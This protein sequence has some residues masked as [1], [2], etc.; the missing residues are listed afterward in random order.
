MDTNL[1]NELYIAIKNLINEGR[2]SVVKNVNTVMV[3]TYWKIGK[4]ISNALDGDNRAEYGEGFIDTLAEKLTH[5]FGKGFVARNLR[6]FRQFYR[7]FPIWNS[8]SSKLSWTHYRMLLRVENAAERQYFYEET[9]NSDLSTREL[10]KKILNSKPA[11]YKIKKKKKIWKSIVP[12][13]GFDKPQTA[14]VVNNPYMMDFLG[15][16][17][18]A[19]FKENRL[20]E[21]LILRLSR[22]LLE[23]NKGFCFLARHKQIM[24]KNVVRYIDLVFYNAFLKCYVVILVEATSANHKS[25]TKIEDYKLHFDNQFRRNDDN[26]TI[27]LFFVVENNRL[28]ARYSKATKEE[29]LFKSKYMAELPTEETLSEDINKEK[30]ILEIYNF[31][32]EGAKDKNIEVLQS[33]RA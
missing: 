6:Y 13:K 25:A 24:F 28:I 22:Y 5:E 10:S 21:S 3:A 33:F 15:L 19:T 18:N 27:G 20:E 8:V 11:S 31:D 16:Q 4:E 26:P 32:K 29:S 2:T 30:D 1:E 23:L 7:Y 17:N 14:K 9:C 12:Q